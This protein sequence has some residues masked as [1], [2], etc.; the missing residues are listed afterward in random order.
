M[1]RDRRLKRRRAVTVMYKW[2][3]PHFSH[4]VFLMKTLSQIASR[5]AN[6]T[7]LQSKYY[8]GSFNENRKA[9]TLSHFV[10]QPNAN[11]SQEHI[12]MN[13]EWIRG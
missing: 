9:E 3:H 11:D 7:Q 2:K 10:Y 1:C 4:S 8:L 6:C 13:K 12:C 5:R